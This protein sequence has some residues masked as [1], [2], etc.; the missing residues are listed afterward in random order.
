MISN[1]QACV[2][3]VQTSSK[4]I[5]RIA[6]DTLAPIQLQLTSTNDPMVIVQAKGSTQQPPR[7]I[8]LRAEAYDTVRER[9]VLLLQEMKRETMMILKKKK[10]KL[11][12]E[13]ANIRGK[14]NSTSL[15]YPVTVK[16]EQCRHVAANRIEMEEANNITA[17]KTDTRKV[18]LQLKISEAF[19]MCRFIKLI[20]KSS[21]T[22][23]DAFVHIGGKLAE[24]PNQRRDT[25][26]RE[27]IRIMK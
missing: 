7:N 2:A 13:D 16:V 27:M 21:N 15:I 14:P 19:D 22:I 9:A 4:G 8:L 24:L 26:A 23:K 10:V 3:S 20:K 25:V 5:N 12:N 11:A 17:K 1:T 6:E 18:H